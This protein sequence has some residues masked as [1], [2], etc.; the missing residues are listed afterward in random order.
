MLK[1]RESSI[2]AFRQPMIPTMPLTTRGSAKRSSVMTGVY[3]F[4]LVAIAVAIA[5][6]IVIVSV[7]VLVVVLRR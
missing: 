3:V 2:P 4:A 6:V 1:L 5:V 7:V